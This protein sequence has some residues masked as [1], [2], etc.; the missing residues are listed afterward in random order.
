[1]KVHE[2]IHEKYY[3]DLNEILTNEKAWHSTNT[4]NYLLENS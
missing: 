1:M 4:Q 2:K 3:F